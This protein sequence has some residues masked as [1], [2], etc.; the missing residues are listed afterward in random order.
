[1]QATL[2]GV[3]AGKVRRA[4][5]SKKVCG[6]WKSPF[7]GWMTTGEVFREFGASRWTMMQLRRNGT[8]QMFRPSGTSK[9]ILYPRAQVEAYFRPPLPIEDVKD[10]ALEY[11]GKKSGKEA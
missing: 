4:R 1:M 5:K 6:P 3:E 11:R 10:P 9:K 8:I 7:E 2:D